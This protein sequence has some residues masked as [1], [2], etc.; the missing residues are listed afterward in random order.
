MVAMLKVRPT[1]SLF[2]SSEE[3]KN[4]IWQ[5]TIIV[6]KLHIFFGTSV[7]KMPQIASLETYFSPSGL[8]PPG[9]C[10]TPTGYFQILA[11]YFKICGE[12]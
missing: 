7:P 6:S 10:N 11:D 5:F 4:L 12:H 1:C 3:E 2:T 8:R 9:T